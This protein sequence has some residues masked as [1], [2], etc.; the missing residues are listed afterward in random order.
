MLV[1]G[2][3]YTNIIE[4]ISAGASLSCGAEDD[5]HH[6]SGDYR[7]GF[8]VG[9]HQGLRQALAKIPE[10]RAEFWENVNVPGENEELNQS[11]EKAGRVADFLELAE[12][13]CLDALHR[14]ESCGGHFRA[15]S[16]TE[17]GEALRDDEKYSFV[18]A[19]EW[20]G[21]GQPQVR[22]EEPLHF[23][24]VELSRRSYK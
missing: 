21:P 11:L 14:T 10:L 8:I 24:S 19:W 2:L 13:M 15:E 4:I 6:G 22:H 16:Q 23:E 18:S 9:E 5:M 3:D 12:L 7:V 17:D 1:Q 20:Q